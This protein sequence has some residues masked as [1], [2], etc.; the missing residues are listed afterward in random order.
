[1]DIKNGLERLRKNP[2][3]L[4]LD[5]T[6]ELFEAC[7]LER[8][9]FIRSAEFNSAAPQPLA[10]REALENLENLKASVFNKVLKKGF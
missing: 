4:T 9:M 10:V 5:E 8:M 1:M 2:D 3:S 7:L 6:L